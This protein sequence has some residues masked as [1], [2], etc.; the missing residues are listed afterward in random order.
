MCA[1][2][3]F[4]R[5]AREPLRWTHNSQ[6]HQ[7]AHLL[8]TFVCSL[9]SGSHTGWHLFIPIVFSVKKVLVSQLL[10]VPL[11]RFR[12]RMNRLLPIL[13]VFLTA[14]MGCGGGAATVAVR[15]VEAYAV[16]YDGGACSSRNTQH[17]RHHEATLN[18]ARGMNRISY[19]RPQRLLPTHGGGAGKHTARWFALQRPWTRH[20]VFH[21]DG[22]W[23]RQRAPFQSAASCDY[24]VF[25]LRRILC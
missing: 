9:D 5:H 13:I 2:Y 16:P 14:L 24:Y 19:S 23:R 3:I 10:F 7:L 12:S 8:I 22:R 6:G 11:R 15:A 17:G 4:L 21:H 25:A 18:D 20:I 1:T